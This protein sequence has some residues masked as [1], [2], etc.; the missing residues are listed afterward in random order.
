MSVRFP[1][2]VLFMSALSAASLGAC[3]SDNSGPSCNHNNMA[4]GDEVCDGPDL[5]GHTCMD[6]TMNAKPGGTLACKDCQLDETN[7]TGVGGGGG[8]G[9]GTGTGGA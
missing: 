1:A 6:A 2:I 9:G 4:D 7:C 8:M 3:G 5:H